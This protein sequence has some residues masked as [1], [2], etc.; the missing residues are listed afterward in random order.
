MEARILPPS[1]IC[2]HRNRQLK[3][4]AFSIF[5]FDFA[6]FHG[7]RAWRPVRKLRCFDVQGSYV[8]KSAVSRSRTGPGIASAKN[9]PFEESK[10]SRNRV[11]RE[12]W[13][14]EES[15]LL[16]NRIFRE[17]WL[18]G[19]SQLSKNRNSRGIWCFEES[20]LSKNR[21]C[22]EFRRIKETQMSSSRRC[23]GIAGVD[24]LQMS[25]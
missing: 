3:T 2:R 25:K 20:L 14:V 9:P 23:R 7:F 17:L 11:C 18:F 24:E 15:Q 21:I 5:P 12:I 8:A 10:L 13:R 16:K 6:G 19:K 4:L 1:R 22:R